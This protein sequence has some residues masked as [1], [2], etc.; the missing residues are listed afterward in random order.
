MKE[1]IFDLIKENLKNPKLYLGLFIVIIVILLLF[2]YIDANFFYYNRVERRIDILTKALEIDKEKINDNE[3]LKEEY[4]SILNEIGKQK[5]G[6]L[7]SVFITQN[8]E[9]VNRWKFFTG[10]VVLWII[11]FICLFVKMDSW[12]YKIF[13]FVLF[14]I[15]GC[16]VGYIFMI[17]PTVISPKCNYIMVPI[18]QLV[19]FGIL[20]TGTNKK[21]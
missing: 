8:S 19:I 6:S 16:L 11:A 10:A 21:Q 7:G 12:W 5:D 14:G 1:K 18:L 13:G 9:M 20:I 17:L 3:I 2:P 4:R 15:I